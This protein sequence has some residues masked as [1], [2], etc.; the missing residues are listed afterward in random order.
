[1][2]AEELW[3]DMKSEERGRV[4]NNLFP[5]MPESQRGS[6]IELSFDDITGVDEASK[7]SIR[8][9]LMLACTDTGFS[10]R[11]EAATRRRFG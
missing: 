1:M 9:T 6:V 7:K 8:G 10:I 11:E 4:L 3:D 5:D 2:L